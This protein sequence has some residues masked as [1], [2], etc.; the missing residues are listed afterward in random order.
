MKVPIVN[1]THQGR[2]SNGL[3]K[4]SKIVEEPKLFTPLAHIMYVHK[5]G[6]WGTFVRRI[7]EGF[8]TTD[9]NANQQ[10]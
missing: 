8:W 2:R 5:T 4:S 1:Q 3:K 9:I 7:D 6:S 10:S